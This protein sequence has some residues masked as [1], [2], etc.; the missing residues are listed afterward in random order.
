MASVFLTTAL[1]QWFAEYGDFANLDSVLVAKAKEESISNLTEDLA[2]E[3]A[4]L[5]SKQEF[6]ESAPKFSKEFNP[7]KDS[8]CNAKLL[9]FQQEAGDLIKVFCNGANFLTTVAS[10]AE[11]FLP[12]EV[13]FDK[14]DCSSFTKCRASLKALAGA[15]ENFFIVKRGKEAAM[16]DTTITVPWKILSKYTPSF[17]TSA[18]VYLYVTGLWL[19]P[20]CY[21]TWFVSLVFKAKSFFNLSTSEFKALASLA[22]SLDTT[23]FGLFSQLRIQLCPVMKSIEMFKGLYFAFTI[24]GQSVVHYMPMHCSLQAGVPVALDRKNFLAVMN[25]GS[26]RKIEYQGLFP[27]LNGL[28]IS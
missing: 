16:H 4:G 7:R 25:S 14:I 26:Y 12:L 15:P 27:F 17:V 5:G 11:G 18:L 22:E 3:L 19:V 8:S 2:Y 13:F 20:A 24:E 23:I 6:L 21:R 10:S 28:Q 9:A 1:R